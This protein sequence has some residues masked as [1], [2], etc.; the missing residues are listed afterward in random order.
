VAT[1]REFEIVVGVLMEE[2]MIDVPDVVFIDVPDDVLRND[3]KDDLE[4]LSSLVEVVRV[5]VEYFALDRLRVDVERNVVVPSEGILE[6]VLED[7]PEFFD[8]LVLNVAVPSS[9][10]LVTSW[11]RQSI[12][13]NA[14]NRRRIS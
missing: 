6:D 13:R 4:E 3:F 9:G 5:F 12:V 14:E 2:I 1:V 10:V 7:V 8:E 11:R